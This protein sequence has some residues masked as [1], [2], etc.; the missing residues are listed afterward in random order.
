MYSCLIVAAISS[1]GNYVGDLLTAKEPH[2]IIRKEAPVKN[3][4]FVSNVLLGNRVVQCSNI[5]LSSLE[6]IESLWEDQ[7]RHC[8]GVPNLSGV[9]EICWIL[10]LPDLF[11]SNAK[12]CW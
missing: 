2:Y 9:P 11:S 3:K 8:I 6:V 10:S 12:T 7:T 1:S 5:L 4:D